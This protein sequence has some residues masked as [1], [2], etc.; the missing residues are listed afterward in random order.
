MRYY[1]DKTKKLYSTEDELKAAEVEY[2]DALLAEKKKRE[3][4]EARAKE[5][6]DAIKKANDLLKKFNEDYGPF[7]TSVDSSTLFYHLLD[8]WF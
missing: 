2:D 7:H 4:R 3:D 6:N 1:S 5:V 8:F